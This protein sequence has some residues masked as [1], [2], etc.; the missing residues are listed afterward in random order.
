[1]DCSSG[2][3][4]AAGA[5]LVTGAGCS[6]RDARE[7]EAWAVA[8]ATWA[9]CCTAWTFLGGTIWAMVVVPWT[10]SWVVTAVV[11]MVEPRGG[12]AVLLEPYSIL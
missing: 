7:C 9:L 1:M 3:G 4:W 2:A 11:A 5:G 10:S 12:G 8:S 6:V